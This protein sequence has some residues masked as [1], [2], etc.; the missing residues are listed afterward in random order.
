MVLDRIAKDKIK[1][2]IEQILHDSHNN[3]IRITIPVKCENK[4]FLI[5]EHLNQYMIKYQI[6]VNWYGQP[7]NSFD[8]L[9]KGEVIY[10]CEYELLN[11]IL[12]KVTKVL[13]VV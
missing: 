13:E 7:D 12:K 9:D 2:T 5:V 1:L 4:Y 6:C 10:N 11:T 3:K 8:T